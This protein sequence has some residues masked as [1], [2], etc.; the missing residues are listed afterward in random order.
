MKQLLKPGPVTNGDSSA[1]FGGA[2]RAL[3]LVRVPAL[4][5]P[6]K[7]NFEAATDH[8]SK[9]VL[10]GAIPITKTGPTLVSIGPEASSSAAAHLSIP[11]P[12]LWR[13][14]ISELAGGNNRVGIFIL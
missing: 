10:L 5:G 14:R 2:T 12:A 13:V 3:L 6:F 11:C 1:W 8:L 9:A 4:A 7:L